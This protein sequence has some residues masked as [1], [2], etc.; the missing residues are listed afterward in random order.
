MKT[1]LHNH[2]QLKHHPSCKNS[3]SKSQATPLLLHC[4][5]KPQK[6]K[7]LKPIKQNSPGDQTGY[8]SRQPHQIP[9]KITTR[10]SSGKYNKRLQ[11][12]FAP[13]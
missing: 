8:S 6:T 1:F 7:I 4:K 2:T 9:I 10:S 3:N 5:N 11:T 13:T 12:R